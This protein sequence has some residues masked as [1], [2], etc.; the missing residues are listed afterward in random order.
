[1]QN[2]ILGTGLSGLVGSRIV[3]LLSQK[4]SFEDVSRKQGIDITDAEKLHQT[5]SA[6]E[7]PVVLHFAARTDVDGC[8]DEKEL[9]KN[10]LSWKI[11][12]EGTRNVVQACKESGKKIIFIST[13]M[14]FDGTKP[15]GERYGEDD[16]PKPM[17]WYAM[18]KFEAEKII[19]QAD[20]PWIILR[21][22]YP[23]RSNYIKKEY[24]RAFIQ[25]LQNNQEITAV[26]DHYFTPTFID[27][28]GPVLDILLQG[29]QT[30]IF[31]AVGKQVVS[32]YDAAVTIARTFGLN[33]ELIKKITREEFFADRAPRPFNLSLKNDKIEKI[34]CRMMNF[35]DGVAIIKK[36][37]LTSRELS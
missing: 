10:S 14:V 4:Y 26:S 32:P 36:Q 15:L 11:N 21:I 13:D 29:D 3:E 37:L 35:E 2:K 33:E 7:S 20:L 17:N 1:M 30:G 18:T 27:D 5:I 12:V 9:A 16:I 24:V 23:Y 31:H 34:D 19:M 6:S 22:A 28:L 8:E 25:L